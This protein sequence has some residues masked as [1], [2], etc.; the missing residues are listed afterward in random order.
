MRN[1]NH[2]ELKVGDFLREKKNHL[3]YWREFNIIKIIEKHSFPT[4]KGCKAKCCRE[5]Y[6][7]KITLAEYIISNKNIIIRFKKAEIN[8]I[9]KWMV[10]YLRDGDHVIKED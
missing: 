6:G 10:E 1:L 7:G 2:D 5:G 9:F 4:G 8:Y 3:E